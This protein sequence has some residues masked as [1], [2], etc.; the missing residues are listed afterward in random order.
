[1]VE[2]PVL[3]ITFCRP[4]YARHSFDAIKKAQPRKLYFYSNK[5]R[6]D[7][8]DEVRRNE[9]VRSFV[10]EINWD[11]EVK[12]WF[13]DEYVDIY[14]SL[15]GAMDWLFDNEE[16]GIVLEEDCVASLPFFTYCEKMLNYFQDDNR[17]SIISGNNRYPE[18]NP[19]GVDYFLSKFIDIYG[20]ATW[21]DRWH[22][23]DRN[24]KLWPR[25]RL[26]VYQ[27]YHNL[28]Q[29]I[30]YLFWWERMYRKI[31]TYNPWD[32]INSYNR[33]KNKTFGIIPLCNLVIDI[34]R[35]GAHHK[36]VNAD[37]EHDETPIEYDKRID[38][39]Y[40]CV[41]HPITVYKSY[42]D[43][44][45]KANNKKSIQYIFKRLLHR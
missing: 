8:P 11:C 1:M 13:R 30:W 19:E 22:A 34:G 29:T 7:R 35:Y 44:R 40:N 32:S 21:A 27:H 31:D 25:V 43:N 18:Y 5:A 2:V 42:D 16:K 23:L 45:F 12:T 33:C 24:M 20:W 9:E 26:K 15:W 4:E 41:K 14:T 39:Y 6:E 37:D 10:N 3:Y 17:V 28:R 36:M 38:E